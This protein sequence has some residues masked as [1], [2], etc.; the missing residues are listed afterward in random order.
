MTRDGEDAVLRAGDSVTLGRGKWATLVS[1]IEGPLVIEVL[2][3][4]HPRSPAIRS[5]LRHRQVA[6]GAA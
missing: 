6:G 3:V 5:T 2:G 4:D 1:A